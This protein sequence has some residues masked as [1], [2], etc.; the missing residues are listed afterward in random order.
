MNFRSRHSQLTWLVAGL[1]KQ[2]LGFEPKLVN[3]GFVVDNMPMGQ[4]FFW[5][6]RFLLSIS[7]LEYFILTYSSP[8]LHKLSN[9]QHPHTSTRVCGLDSSGSGQKPEIGNVIP[10]P[11]LHCVVEALGC[12]YTSQLALCSMFLLPTSFIFTSYDM[13]EF[14]S[15]FLLGIA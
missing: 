7:L 5:V 6:L 10:F 3:I 14:Y 11:V 1:L 4:V 15:F 9:W 8:R 13:W 12:C 2:R